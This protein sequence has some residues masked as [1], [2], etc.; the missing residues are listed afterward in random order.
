MQPP[1]PGGGPA[2]PPPSPYFAPP[3]PQQG[4]STQAV[5]AL[6]LSLISWVLCGCLLSI[7]AIFVAQAEIRAIERGESSPAGKG[8]AQAAFWVAVANVIVYV[9]LIGL[10]VALVATGIVA[11]GLSR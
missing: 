10:Y 8:M 6:V 3:P 2:W 9:L 1:P 11:A 7:P 5:A 4:A